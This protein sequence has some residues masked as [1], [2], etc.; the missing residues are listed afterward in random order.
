MA[1]NLDVIG[2]RMDPVAFRYDEDT[3]MLYALGIGAGVQELDFVYEKNLKVFPTFAVIPLLSVLLPFISA[4]G[5]NFYT[6]LHGEQK[7]VLHNPIPTSGTV[8]TTAICESIYDKGDKGAV[9]NLGLETRDDAGE[10]LFENETVLVDRSA[11]NFGGDPG[12]KGQKLDP[13]AGV[14]PDFRVE[15]IIPHNQAALYRLSGDKNRLHIDPAF[16][17]KGGFDRPILHGLCSLGYAG[18]AILGSVCQ[19][20]PARFKSFAVRFMN[21]V[22]PGDTLITE[23]WKLGPNRYA[24]QTAN[25]DGKIVLGNGLAVT[26]E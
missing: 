19:G 14:S 15:Q 25:Q 5:I 3:V 7:I 12:P 20:D 6:M 2:K 23:G 11:G 17:R 4:A 16:A 9:V 24:I 21:V 22:Y 13:P 18:R 1:I 26:D 8:H 10:L